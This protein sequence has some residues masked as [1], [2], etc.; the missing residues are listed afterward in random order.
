MAQHELSA[1]NQRRIS[2]VYEDDGMVNTRTLSAAR[3]LIDNDVKDF[4]DSGSAR[5]YAVAIEG[6]RQGISALREDPKQAGNS[7]MGITFVEVAEK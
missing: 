4:L 6:H 3:K 7:Q 5:A 1:T 2:V